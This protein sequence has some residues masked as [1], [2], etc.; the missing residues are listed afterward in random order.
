M[1]MC[2]GWSS[3]YSTYLTKRAR[4]LLQQRRLTNGWKTNKTHTRIA[5]FGHIK[6]RT[7]TPSTTSS[8]LGL[9]NLSS[10]LRE[11]RL[12]QSEMSRCCLILLCP[13]HFILNVLDLCQ[14]RRHR[15]GFFH[16]TMTMYTLSSA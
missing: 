5:C 16:V 12:E 8:S 11:L 10:Q 4:E 3:R 6:A 9:K 15:C 14:S 1:Q 13:C 7:S 2:L